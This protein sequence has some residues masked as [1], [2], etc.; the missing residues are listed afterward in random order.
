MDAEA[1]EKPSLEA[2]KTEQRNALEKPSLE[3]AK[4]ELRKPLEKPSLEAANAGKMKG[5]EK[6]TMKIL[7]GSVSGIMAML[8]EIASH[9]YACG[10]YCLPK[11]ACFLVSNAW[12]I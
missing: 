2:A 6:P 1:L 10:T 4:A 7:E 11:K 5:L 8:L 12:P 9:L 3:A